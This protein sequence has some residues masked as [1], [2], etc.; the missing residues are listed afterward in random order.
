MN[1]DHLQR[2]SASLGLD[3]VLSSFQDSDNPQSRFAI[4][5]RSGARLDTVYEMS[6]HFLE[7]FA[8]R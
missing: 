7:G 3:A 6:G 5:N 4:A 1:F 2:D 8:S